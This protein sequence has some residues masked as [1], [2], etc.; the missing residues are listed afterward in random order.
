M[1]DEIVSVCAPRI[2]DPKSRRAIENLKSARDLEH[3]PLIWRERG[4]G[5]RVVVKQVLKEHGLATTKD[6]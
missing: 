2:R 4:A 6:L 1:P 5:T 3:L